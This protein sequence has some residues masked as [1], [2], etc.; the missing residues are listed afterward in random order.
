MNEGSTI[1]TYRR[2]PPTLP[3]MKVDFLEKNDN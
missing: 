2:E 1:I 3:F